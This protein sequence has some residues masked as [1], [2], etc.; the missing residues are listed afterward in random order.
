M[1]TSICPPENTILYHLY[2]L[3]R[4]NFSGQRNRIYDPDVFD[5]EFEVFA[6]LLHHFEGLIVG[7]Q[8]LDA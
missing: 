6:N 1:S 3:V 8:D 2:F 4:A 5:P 7:R